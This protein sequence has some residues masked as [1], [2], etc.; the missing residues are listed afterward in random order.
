MWQMLSIQDAAYLAGLFDGEG[1][2][3]VGFCKR[4]SRSNFTV[5]PVLTITNTHRKTLEWVRDTTGSGQIV[6]TCKGGR[7]HSP[8]WAYRIGELHHIH[9]L[10]RQVYPF[11]RIKSARALLMIQYTNRRINDLEHRG[12]NREDAKLI[13]RIRLA[14]QRR[15]DGVPVFGKRRSLSQFTHLL[16]DGR[17]ESIYRKAVWTPEKDALLGTVSDQQ[18]ATHLGMGARTVW[19]RRQLLKIKPFKVTWNSLEGR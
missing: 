13:Y 3:T 16:L 6:Q 10:L 2:I 18:L 14:N 8:C 15:K 4:Q 5:M 12:Y 1:C 7:V 17:T 11:L 9:D 19:R